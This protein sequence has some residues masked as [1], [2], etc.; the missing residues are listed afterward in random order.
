MTGLLVLKA[1]GPD[2]ARSPEFQYLLSLDLLHA[3]DAFGCTELAV[4]GDSRLPEGPFDAVL[5]LGDA[6]V[7]LARSSLE[8]MRDRLLAGATEVRPYRLADTGL[9]SRFPVYTLR[10][11]ERL[12][13]AF[14]EEGSGTLPAP[15]SPPAVAL[16]RF[17]EFARRAAGIPVA[18][19]LSNPVS[20]AAPPGAPGVAHAGL[21]HEFI[22]YY[23]EVRTDILPFL[24]PGAREVLE[25]GCGRGATGRLLQERLG[26][27]VT[28]VELNPV[29][30]R[31]AARHLYRVLQGDVQT[32]EIAGRYDAVIALE[33]VE[34]LVDSERFLARVRELLAP[35][36]R[37]VFSIPNVGHW[38]IIDDLLTGRWDY[39]PVGLL[40]YTHFRFFTRRSL[41]DWLR[42]SGI[43]R[44]EI[45]PQR[46][47]LPDRFAA[48]EGPFEVNAESLS[49]KGFYVVVHG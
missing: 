23:G 10:G 36:G 24:P 1:L 18:D 13:R 12:E 30:A 6:N 39:L 14:L 40:C 20:L 17:D 9:A 25:V 4:S 44:F 7:L 47:E 8:A 28:G 29:V 35:G 33:L 34:H 32:L 21:Y 19:L 46:T 43:D 22:D 49:T 16:L 11:Y 41:A 45:V 37:A 15:P 31:E 26:C 3:R 42:R 38:S 27:R 2:S 48:L 5:L